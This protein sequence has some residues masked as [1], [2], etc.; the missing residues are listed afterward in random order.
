M[1]AACLGRARQT[2]GRRRH[3][4][5]RWFIYVEYCRPDGA[6]DW[7]AIERPRSQDLDA[8]FGQAQW[9]E[10][11]DIDPQRTTDWLDAMN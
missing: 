5:L 7:A 4:R 2:Q 6:R 11:P 1:S 9:L 8:L 3:P 10:L